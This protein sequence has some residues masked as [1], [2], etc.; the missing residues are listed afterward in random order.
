MKLFFKINSILPVNTS[1]VHGVYNFELAHIF[2][3]LNY[4][5]DSVLVL[6]DIDLT[7]KDYSVWKAMEDSERKSL[8]KDMVF[9]RCKDLTQLKVLTNRIDTRFATALG[10]SNGDLKVTNDN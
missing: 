6:V 2:T 5:Y 8:M 10:F 3:L 7:N 4:G 9:I 1:R